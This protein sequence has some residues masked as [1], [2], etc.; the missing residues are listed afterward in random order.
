MLNYSDL[1]EWEWEWCHLS[2]QMGFVVSDVFL[3]EA[4]N[5]HRKIPKISPS[6][7]KPFQS[8]ISPPPPPPQAGNAKK[9]KKHPLN[10]PSKYKPLGVLYLENCPKI[11]SKTKQK[12]SIYF[13]L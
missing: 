12:S 9:K 7:Y 5:T 3:T 2:C 11:Q 4:G 1:L 10:H 13:Q 8:N 6:M